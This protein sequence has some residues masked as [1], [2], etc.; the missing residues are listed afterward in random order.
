MQFRSG[1]IGLMW[2]PRFDA[3]TYRHQAPP[4]LGLAGA[5]SKRNGHRRRAGKNPAGCPISRVLRVIPVDC[6]GLEGNRS[7]LLGPGRHGS[8]D[9]CLDGLATQPLAPPANPCEFAGLYPATRAR[10]H[11][12][13]S[14]LAWDDDPLRCADIG[15]RYDARGRRR[16]AE[17]SVTGWRRRTLVPG[18]GIR[19]ALPIP[20][21][22][23]ITL[24]LAGPYGIP[25][26]AELPAPAD[27]AGGGN[28]ARAPTGIIKLP[29]STK[30]DK[31]RSA[32]HWIS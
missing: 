16:R 18:G 31:H 13:R 12:S 11:L 8:A 9:E 29:S 6:G 21:G 1:I 7:G 3:G 10:R 25:L 28:C 14:C 32:G 24:G 19:E 26:I 17:R 27:P 2:C 15:R 30:A 20:L 4:G 5:R 22:S 23:P